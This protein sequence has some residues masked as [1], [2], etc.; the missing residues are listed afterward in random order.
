MARSMPQHLFWHVSV[1]G[2]NYLLHKPLKSL[3]TRHSSHTHLQSANDGACVGAEKNLGLH[4]FGLQLLDATFVG[5]QP[6]YC[7]GSGRLRC[8]LSLVLFPLA[9]A[10]LGL[11]GVPA[12]LRDG[13]T[14]LMGER[15]RLPL[16]LELS[17]AM[18]MDSIP[19][20]A[21]LGTLFLVQQHRG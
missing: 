7:R 10:V 8:I 3:P 18:P 12:I 17:R 20:T 9:T 13:V 1:L 6:G 19:L 15:G 16:A 21:V 4:Q 11:L 5:P 2:R 14:L